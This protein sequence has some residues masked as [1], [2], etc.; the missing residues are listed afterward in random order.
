MHALNL[1]TWLSACTVL[2]VYEILDQKHAYIWKCMLIINDW[3]RRFLE[4]TGFDC[5]QKLEFSVE[6]H[7]I[8][9]LA[10]LSKLQIHR[11]KPHRPFHPCS[12]VQILLDCHPVVLR[13]LGN[14]L[15][16]SSPASLQSVIHPI[17]SV[18]PPKYCSNR[19]IL[20]IPPNLSS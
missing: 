14:H 20:S 7:R 8:S 13:K 12:P 15:S 19:S 18:L 6:G 1:H 9:I 3:S 2:F 4:G 11:A 16:P 17:L 5:N 10:P